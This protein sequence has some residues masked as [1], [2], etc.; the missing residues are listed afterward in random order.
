MIGHRVGDLELRVR[1]SVPQSVVPPSEAAQ[2]VGR[3]LEEAGDRLERRFPGWVILIR[4]LP[5]RWRMTVTQLGS[6]AAIAELVQ[7][8]TGAVA[9][10]P[11]SGL[12]IPGEADDLAVFESEAQWRAAYLASLADREGGDRWCF[13]A[14]AAESGPWDFLETTSS[15]AELAGAVCAADA[16]PG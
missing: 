7:G 4:E 6:D 10:R 12:A 16:P 14:L 9:F 5:L 2:F 15:S 1:S 3:V 11:S 13:R 8:L